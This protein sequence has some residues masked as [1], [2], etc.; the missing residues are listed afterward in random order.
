MSITNLASQNEKEY[1]DIK[2]NKLDVADLNITN[3]SIGA[4]GSDN[5][6]PSLEAG[7]GITAVTFSRAHWKKINDV[8]FVNLYAK[9]DADA[10]SSGTVR[11]ARSDLFYAKATAFSSNDEVIGV[12]VYEDNNNFRPVYLR[13]GS[14]G[15]SDKIEFVFQKTSAT[16]SGEELQVNFSYTTD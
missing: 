3:F 4:V 14:G 9:V 1:L 13:L 16:L 2:V 11:I 5:N 10:S 12:G 6:V 7:P 15:N 8:I